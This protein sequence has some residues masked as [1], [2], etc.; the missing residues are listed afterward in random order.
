MPPFGLKFLQGLL[1]G[2]HD[3]GGRREAPFAVPL[4]H[5]LP[6]VVDVERKR[7]RHALAPGQFAAAGYDEPKARHAL[8]A[9]VGAADE[10][11][12]AQPVYVEGN[13]AEAAHG[14]DNQ[15]F[16]VHLHDVG[17][18]LQGVQYAGRRLAVDD[19]HVGYFGVVA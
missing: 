1:E 2:T 7:A 16:A 3:V 19:G 8:Y 6:L 13:A 14:I 11:V 17:H 12:Y 15:T 10:E 18:L 4:L 9:L 5:G